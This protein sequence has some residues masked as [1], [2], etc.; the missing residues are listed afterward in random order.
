MRKT[1]KE[2]EMLYHASQEER[3]ELRETYDMTL[4][5]QKQESLLLNDFDRIE[6]AA[7]LM[8]E[9]GVKSKFDY[10]YAAVIYSRGETT[11]DYKKACSYSEQA[12]RLNED[13]DPS[14]EFYQQASSVYEHSFDKVRLS[15]GKMPRYGSKKY[16]DS[17]DYG[18]ELNGNNNKT[19][20]PKPNPMAIT[21]LNLQKKDND[22]KKEEELKT[23]PSVCGKCGESGHFSSS[24]LKPKKPH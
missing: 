1:T 15:E 13:N 24:C 20:T 5:N 9:L 8:Q 22:K 23:K 21:P 19:T 6:A 3:K 18:L 17:N 16:S 12:I 4:V 2:L 14:D 7:V 10:F 11:S